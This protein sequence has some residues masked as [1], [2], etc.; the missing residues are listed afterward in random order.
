LEIVGAR[1][2]GNPG[3]EGAGGGGAQPKPDWPRC[4]QKGGGGRTLGF[5]TRFSAGQGGGEKRFPLGP[6][7]R[8]GGPGP[9]RL[10]GAKPKVSFSGQKKKNFRK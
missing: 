1:G 7:K 5:G 10:Q 6:G 8:P 3:G 2:G 4:V 9:V